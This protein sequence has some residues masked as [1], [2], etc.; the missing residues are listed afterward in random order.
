MLKL[1]CC[2]DRHSYFII[3]VLISGQISNKQSKMTV[4]WWGINKRRLISFI[5]LIH[6]IKRP[7][8]TINLL[9]GLCAKAWYVL[10]LFGCPKAIENTTRHTVAL[11]DRFLLYHEHTYC[12]WCWLNHTYISLLSQILTRA[13]SFH[14]A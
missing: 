7:K 2:T 3:T 6:H 5:H 1:C 10:Y 12:I 4:G 14:P 11:S 13:H 9:T 8:A